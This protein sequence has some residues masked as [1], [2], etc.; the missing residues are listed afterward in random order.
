MA[1]LI[2]GSEFL[3]RPV[4]PKEIFTPEDFDDEQ[5]QIRDTTRELVEK[6]ILPQVAEIDSPNFALSV[7]LLAQCGDL[8]LLMT[9]AAEEDGGLDLSKTT[10]MLVAEEI[11]H[12]GA[13]SV[14]FTAH[15]GIGTLPLVYYGTK[16]QKDKYLHKL[17]TGEWPAAYCLTEPGSGSDALDVATTATLEG[18][19]YVLN[20]TKQFITNGGFAKLFTVFAKINKE[21]FSRGQ[22]RPGR[23]K[24]WHQGEFDHAGD[25]GPGESAQGKP[26]GRGGQG[27]LHCL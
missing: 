8:G 12:T 23:K 24:A 7:K 19:H 16:A 4:E 9:D 15:T 10:S 18:D 14:S 25:F 21:H 1:E 13:F 26:A 17:I 2:K 6:E 27:A 5:R 11:A 3:I 20:G 22:H